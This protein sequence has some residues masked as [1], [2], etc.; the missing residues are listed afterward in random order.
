MDQPAFESRRPLDRTLLRLVLDTIVPASDGFP[1]AR[2]AALDHVLDA[3]SASSDVERAI[4]ASLDAVA[5]ASPAFAS[6]DAAGR[7]ASLQRVEAAHPDAFGEVVR[8]AYFGYYGHAD[9]VTRLGLE[10]GPV[11]PRGHRLEDGDVPDL[12]RVTSRGP[13]YRPT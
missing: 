1:S 12:S 7:E 2:D 10:P 9:V 11:H 5:A 6:L 3:A 13:V 4:V 8:Q